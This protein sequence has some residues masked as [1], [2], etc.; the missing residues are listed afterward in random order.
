MSALAVVRT[1]SLFVLVSVAGCATG[2]VPGSVDAGRGGLD[3]G[4]MMDS[5]VPMVDAGRFPDASNCVSICGATADS[6]VDGTCRCGGGGAC[7]GGFA[8]CGGTCVDPTITAAHCGTCGNACGATESCEMGSCAMST[9]TPACGVGETCTMGACRCGA[10]G[11]CSAGQTCCG[12]GCVDVQTNGRHC[13]RCGVECP[14]GQSCMMG[15]CR[16]PTCTG[17]CPSGETCEMGMCRCGAGASCGGGQACCGGRCVDTQTDVAH[18]GSCGRGCMGTERCCA[19]R[20]LDTSA[21]PT[22][23]GTCGNTCN[24]FASDGC[25]MGMCMCG[26]RA[27][28]IFPPICDSGTCPGI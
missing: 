15:S 13:G 25:R 22:N 1:A 20:C 9:C 11:A 24:I 17:G 4:R 28:C 23:C 2:G 7:M 26:T 16:A 12:G 14:A 19:G 3:G 21:D 27:A 6:C 5:R 10:S 18:C 8:C